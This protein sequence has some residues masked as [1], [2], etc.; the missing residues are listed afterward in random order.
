MYDSDVFVDSAFT[1]TATAY[2]D[3][4]GRTHT[5]SDW[6]VSTDSAFGSTI[7][8]VLADTS[9]LT[10]YTLDSGL[11]TA[12]T[13]FWRVR[14]RDNEGDVSNYSANKSFSVTPP[15]PDTLGQSYAGGFYIGTTTSTDSTCYY[16]IVAPN[17]TGCARC[18]WK[19]TNSTTSGAGSC[20]DGYSNTYGPMDNTD[21][22]A[23]NFTAT[24][25]IN[26]YSDWYL[27]AKDELNQLYINKGS[28]P[29]GEGFC[30]ANA[31]SWHWSSTHFSIPFSWV[32]FFENGATSCTACQKVCAAG[33]RAVRREPI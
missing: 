21:H 10:S 32:Q 16:L 17:A 20:N 30:S 13:Y 15:P 14:Y 6:Q 11:D 28:M 9:N 18:S 26:G 33:V 27:P 22:P 19:I 5:S 8:N 7:L 3:N 29:A 2:S 31:G 25:T 12:G 24:R 4:L 23:G 1:L